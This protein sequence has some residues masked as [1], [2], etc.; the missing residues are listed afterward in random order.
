MESSEYS[1]QA[2][3][4]LMSNVAQASRI[5]DCIEK[6]PYLA[7]L[8]VAGLKLSS[9]SGELNDSIVKHVC[10][11]QPLDVVNIKEE[12]GDLLWYINTILICLQSSFDEVMDDNIKKLSI[13]YPEK[14]TDQA[15]LERKDKN[16]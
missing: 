2:V 7:Q 10:Y 9:E 16:A 8:I 15:A 6:R 13:R 4:T 3:R 12:C 5:I 11:G 1:E 14:Y